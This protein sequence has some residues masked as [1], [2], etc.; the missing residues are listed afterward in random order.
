V[1]TTLSASVSSA[2]LSVTVADATG[3]QDD[4]FV[5]IDSNSNVEIVQIDSIA[6][7]TLT[8]KSTT[9]LGR[10]TSRESTS[11][12]LIRSGLVSITMR[13]RMI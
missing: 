9:P 10:I 6:V 1:S 2:A 8:L 5:R 3:L 11:H 12:R 13:R 4:D 7:N